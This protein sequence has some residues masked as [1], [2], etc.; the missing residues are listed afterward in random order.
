MVATEVSS[1]TYEGQFGPFVITPND[2]REVVIYR[3]GLGV[4]AFS[5]ALAVTLLLLGGVTAGLLWLASGLYFLMWVG[6]GVS[7]WFI[8]IYLRPLHQALQ[9]FWLVGGLASIGLAISF[10]APLVLTAY[11]QPLSML[12]IGFTF[13]ALTGIFFKEAFCFNRLETKI[14]TLLVPAMLLTH[15]VGA[16]PVM[17]GRDLL[18][19]WAVLFSVFAF[20]KLVQPIPPDIGDKSVFEYLKQQRQVN[21]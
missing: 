1:E 11:Q 18:I 13:A 9:V 7:L 2:R 21:A 20:R 3:I 4:A 10:P 8:H 15:L 14:L 12:G 19:V 6:L 17:L 5:F 16:L